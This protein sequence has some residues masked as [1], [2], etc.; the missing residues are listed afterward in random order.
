MGNTIIS[1]GNQFR[2]YDSDVVTHSALP[3]G[4]FRINFS[5]LSGYSLQL[6]D[7][8]SVG[9]EKIYGEH[10]AK[11]NRID[12][13]YDHMNRSLGILMSGDKGMGKSLMIRMVAERFRDN[14]GLPVVLVDDN[15]PGLAEFI[16][17]LGESIVVFDEFEK[18]FRDQDD[19][20]KFLGLFDGIS[21]TKRVYIVTV[22]S[23]GRLN[24]YLVNRPGRFHYHIRFN[25]P[26]PAEVREY[27][28]DQVPGIKKNE[29]DQVVLLSHRTKMNY[30]HLRAVAF[31]LRLGGKFVD[32]IG[33][34]NIKNTEETTY[35]MVLTGTDGKS[36]YTTCGLDY[37]EGETQEVT[38]WVGPKGEYL[39]VEFD[40]NDLVLMD[41]TLILP[42]GD[43][44][45]SG[46][47]ALKV[48]QP[49]NIQFEI[50]QQNSY[51]F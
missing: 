40:A 42:L 9:D 3:A 28:H 31:E 20:A 39:E 32:V 4:T 10:D 5:P 38:F 1:T 25:Y 45:F 21:S 36:Y 35:R 6:V 43:A 34:L 46:D 41:D 29:V 44:E 16:D 11:L 19:Q 17:T 51:A 27:V 8:M 24:D 13:A 14:R 2:I 33:D 26:T 50:R 47:E 23:M 15:T 30:D 49:S 12:A 7:N 22:N 18:K 37:R 48:F